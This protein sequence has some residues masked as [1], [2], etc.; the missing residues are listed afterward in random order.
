MVFVLYKV[1]HS[2]NKFC[3]S[4]VFE[5]EDDAENK[6][7]LLTQDKTPEEAKEE[8]FSIEEIHYWKHE[9]YNKKEFPFNYSEEDNDINE[10]DISVESNNVRKRRR[11]EEKSVKVEKEKEKEKE[12]QSNTSYLYDDMS[13]IVVSLILCLLTMIIHIY[14]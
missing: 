7:K 11:I 9:S 10:S 1:N 6:K 3:L 2:N 8:T 5:K 4:G 14:L 13:Y 12:N